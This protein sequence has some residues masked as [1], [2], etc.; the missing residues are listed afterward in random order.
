MLLAALLLPLTLAVTSPALAQPAEAETH[1]K[2]GVSLYQ[3]ADFKAA[4]VE[5]RRAYELS[6]NWR[7]LYNVAQAEYQAHDYAASLASF[8]TFLHEGGDRIARPR[9]LEVEQEALR[10]RVRVGTLTI[11]SNTGGASVVI[12]DEAV[13]LAPLKRHVAVGGRRIVVKKDGYAPWSKNIEIA[14]GDDLLFDAVL[15]PVPSLTAPLS[16]PPPAAAPAKRPFSWEPWAVTGGLAAAAL[17][18]GLLALGA[19]SKLDEEKGRFDVTD[20]ELAEASSRVKT[21]ALVTDILVLAT[22][23]SAGVAVYFTITSPSSRASVRTSPSLSSMLAG[24]RF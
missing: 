5:F 8:E 21:F 2:R 9:R 4:L 12:D 24:G 7:L 11:R 17:T 1:F 23:A 20:R 14:G 16:P 22:I 15:E 6:H 3:E 18:T 10:L 19:S 13:G